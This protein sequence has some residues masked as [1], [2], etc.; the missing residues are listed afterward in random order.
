M[1]IVRSNELFTQKKF[2]S[3]EYSK[4][5]IQG[6]KR[7]QYYQ[8]K[9]AVTALVHKKQLRIEITKFEQMLCFRVFFS[10]IPF[11]NVC[12]VSCE[13]KSGR[14]HANRMDLVT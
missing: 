2:V 14:N 11:Q 7:F 8:V 9:S 5:R 4:L 12:S 13:W 3:Y 10:N 6:M 1:W